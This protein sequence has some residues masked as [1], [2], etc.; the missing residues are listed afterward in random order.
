[1][2]SLQEQGGEGWEC[3]RKKWENE[4]WENARV[5]NEKRREDSAEGGEGQKEAKSGGSAFAQATA[6][7]MAIECNWDAFPIEAMFGKDSGVAPNTLRGL[8]KV[9]FSPILL[10]PSLE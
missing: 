6:K 9:V 2:S 5:K 8:C 7:Q 10:E 4:S 3:K 1:M